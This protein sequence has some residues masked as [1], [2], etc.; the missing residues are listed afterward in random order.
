MIQTHGNL[1]VLAL[2]GYAIRSKYRFD[3]PIPEHK[4][5]FLSNMLIPRFE[6]PDRIPEYI[7]KFNKGIRRLIE[8]LDE[9]VS[10]AGKKQ[11]REEGRVDF[12]KMFISQASFQQMVRDR[13]MK[14]TLQRLQ[15]QV[16]DLS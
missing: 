12:R 5:Q 3:L 6:N 9:W 11:S 13:R 2:V 8:G 15:K 1:T 7:G 4:K 14:K 16:P 10:R